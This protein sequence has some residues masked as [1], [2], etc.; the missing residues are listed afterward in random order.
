MREQGLMAQGKSNERLFHMFM[1]EVFFPESICNFDY[2]VKL[3]I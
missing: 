3:N 1:L 2:H